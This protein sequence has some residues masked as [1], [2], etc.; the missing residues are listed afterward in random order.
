MAADRRFLH[1]DIGRLRETLSQREPRLFADQA[2]RR[3]AVALILRPGSL[4]EP[5]LLFIKRAE[6]QGDPWSGQIAFPGGRRETQD[7]SL[8]HTAIRETREELGVDL[9]AHGTV[10]GMLDE[11]QP[12]SVHLPALVVCP[13][14][15]AVEDLPSLTLSSEVA[16]AFWLPLKSLRDPASWRETEVIA[17]RG[18]RLSRRA[19]QHEGNVIWGITERIIAQLIDL[20]EGE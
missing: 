4:D 8:Q 1:P 10:L 17:A 6:Y 11:L 3:A 16:G 2:M 7:D 15:V 5:E 12:Q 9:G 20:L 18:A 19:Y 14:V 13:F